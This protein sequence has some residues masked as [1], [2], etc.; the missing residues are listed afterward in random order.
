MLTD[1]QMP[2]L[3][4]A[5]DIASKKAQGL[6]V[7]MMR[8]NLIL[9]VVASLTG[10]YSF[11][12][13]FCKKWVAII[14]IILLVVS[15]GIT[16]IVDGYKWEDVWYEGRAVAESAKTLAWRYATCAEPF[17]SNLSSE[18]IDDKLRED[19]GLL[20]NNKKGLADFMSNKDINR[21]Y[22]SEE[23]R[24]AR[25]LS[26]Q[27]RLNGYLIDRVLPQKEWYSGKANFNQNRRNVWFKAIVA[28]QV[29]AIICGVLVA[30]SPDTKINLT[31]F[32]AAITSA[33]IAWLQIRRHQELNRSYN[34]TA[35]ELGSVY[36]K[37]RSVKSE[38]YLAIYIADAEAAISRE[39]TLWLARRDVF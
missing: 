29:A 26:F 23:M 17:L 12:D 14:S 7:N 22:I 39:H 25:T 28:T 20:M 11:D 34:I 5:A 21:L 1:Q 8:A 18:L 38:Q 6:F 15:T 19:L 24:A 13:F 10:V 9:L 32:F 27:D 3:F 4:H 33:G 31:S 2:A 16:L 37:S 35:L 30:S 36:D